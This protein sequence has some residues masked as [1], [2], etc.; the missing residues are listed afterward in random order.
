MGYRA[1]ANRQV[2]VHR[3]WM[4]RTYVLTW[5]FVGCRIV[6]GYTTLP[7]LGADGVTALV[8]LNWIVPLGIAQLMIEW[9]RGAPGPNHPEIRSPLAGP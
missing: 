5:T 8:W 7:G 9:R 6:Q 4:I 1:I 2:C 3:E